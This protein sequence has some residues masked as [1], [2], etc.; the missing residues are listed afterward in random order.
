MYLEFIKDIFQLNDY[1][2]I[3]CG[4]EKTEGFIV[5]ISSELIAIKTSAGIVIKKDADITDIYSIDKAKER[6]KHEGDTEAN[7]HIVVESNSNASVTK[8]THGL[9]S[10]IDSNTAENMVENDPKTLS[11]DTEL[12]TSAADEPQM[13]SLET[14]NTTAVLEPKTSADEEPKVGTNKENDQ[15]DLYET[16]KP[17][18]KVVGFLD[19]SKIN[20]PRK[21]KRNKITAHNTDVEPVHTASAVPSTQN[22]NN[23]INPAT[24]ESKLIDTAQIEKQIN[25]FLQSGKALEAL[26]LI[27]THLKGDYCVGKFKSSL[28]LKRA[29]TYSALSDYEAAKIAYIELI[30]FNESIKSPVNNLS[31]LYTELARLQNLTDEAKEI[32]LA[33]LEKALKYNSSNTYASTLYEQINSE[34]YKANVNNADDNQLLIES[35]E[36]STTISK[37]IDIDIKEHIFTHEKI[38]KNGGTSTPSIAKSIYEE[39]KRTKNVDMSERYPVYLEAAKAYS[40]LPIGSY[41]IQ[42][43]LE[44]VAYYAILKGN[45][46]FIR[47]KKQLAESNPD[48]VSLTHIKDSACS[49]YIESLNLL[50][51]IEGEHLLTIL[52]NYLKMNIALVNVQKGEEPNISGQFGKVFFNCVSSIDK[53][54]NLIA[55]ETIVAIGTASSKAW[56]KLTRIKG[57]TGGLYNVISSPE[58]RQSIYSI[59]NRINDD[60]ISIDLLPGEFLKQSF[61]NRTRRNK[62]FREVLDK[63]L[64]ADF[65]IHMLTTLDALWKKIPDYMDLLS[66]T[67]QESKKTGDKVL[68]NLLPYTS[69]QSQIE[70]TNL[71]YQA[72]D[73]LEK[74]ISFIN[75]NTTYYGRTFFFP[76]FTRWRAIIQQNLKEKISKTLPVLQVIPDPHYILKDGYDLLVNLIIKNIGESTAEGYHLNVSLKSL[77][78]GSEIKGKSKEDKEIPVGSYFDKKMSLPKEFND[79]TSLDLFAEISAVY[80]GE[81]TTAQQYRYTLELEPESSLTEED[82]M[83][84]D[85][86]K[87]SGVLFKGRQDIMDKLTRHYLSVERDKPYIL[88]GLT[89]TG[90]SSILLNLKKALSGKTF[91]KEGE[92]FDLIP[93]EWDLSEAS[94]YGNA[95]DMWQYLLRDTLYDELGNYLTTSFRSELNIDEFPRAKDFKKILQYLKECKKHPMFFVDEFSHIKVLLDN[96]IINTSFLHTLR[97]YSLEGLASF[98]YAGTYDIKELIKDPKYAITGQLVHTI[99]EQINEIDTKS[100]E[101]LI[102][103]MKEKLSF[104]EEAIKHIHLLSGDVPYFIQIICKF[105]GFYAVEKKRRNIGKPELEDVI[106]VLTGEK[107][108]EKD[109]LVKVLPKSIFQNN[110]YSPQDKKEVNVLISSLCYLN[111]NKEIPRGISTPELHELW[112]KNG[113]EAF[114]P[115]LA[116]AITLLLERKVLVQSEDEFIPVYRLSVDLFRRWWKVHNPDIKLEITTI[117]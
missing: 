12:Q 53:N 93:F 88:Y 103:V 44:A 48:I 7:N 47:F 25:G 81:L 101:E 51:N 58:R 21:K 75:D 59:L 19:L 1:I 100:A 91:I 72:Q 29:Q 96:H 106:K 52:A 2:C 6:D 35:E 34:S 115:K 17:Q 64:K 97:Q 78:N 4:N 56:N 111:E 65:N 70:R 112:N 108:G 63:V 43:Y 68:R 37:M 82:V 16:P 15:T 27:T 28:L 98:I 23:E 32:I 117:Q 69:R 74:Q 95:K 8:K 46:L 109:S 76:L 92:R 22:G 73:D 90:K 39:A 83:W 33:T 60:P 30:E 5:K 50:S 67:D 10:H 71:L 110:L 20:D 18:V 116:E 55:W 13:S 107:E 38:I 31:H 84:K 41:D 77:N 89:R 36:I 42:E 9:T 57:G 62:Q 66:E 94:G 3:E 80:Q 114:R 45:S 40:V 14:E 85:G 49:Y 102:N 26:A 105:C 24:I 99:E 87:M 11:S 86:P 54:I 61:A 104:T 113:I 79:C